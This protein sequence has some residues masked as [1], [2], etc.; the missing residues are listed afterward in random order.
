M[1]DGWLKLFVWCHSG[2]NAC[3]ILY[4]II[5]FPCTPKI[6]TRIT[7][8][9]SK[10]WEERDLNA[11]FSVAIGRSRLFFSVFLIQFGREHF[12]HCFS[13]TA[14]DLTCWGGRIAG[15][16]PTPCPQLFRVDPIALILPQP[17]A[18]PSCGRMQ[19]KQQETGILNR[20]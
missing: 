14:V 4:R 16:W 11:V 13:P 1:K 10:S 18:A 19:H 5:L 12:H 8:E 3:K 7:Q 17:L 6:N 20:E 15:R 9:T 2:S